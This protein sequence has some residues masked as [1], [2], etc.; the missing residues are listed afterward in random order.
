MANKVLTI[1]PSRGRPDKIV[2]FY[3]CFKSTAT[4]SDLCIAL[5]D[6]DIEYPKFDD[7]I[8]EIN[9]RMFMGGTLNFVAKKYANDYEYLAF[10]GDDHHARTPGW[11]AKLVESIKDLKNGIAYG[12]DLLAGEGLPT[13][14]LLNSNI[15][16]TLGYMSP[17]ELIHL[18]IDNFW[19][20]IGSNLQ[21]LR[22]SEDV[23]IE[24]MHYS[25]K[26]SEEDSRYL[27][28]NDPEV[29]HHDRLVFEKYVNTQLFAD[30]LKLSQ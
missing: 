10:L 12:N 14:V 2:H 11:D 30:L 20:A 17:P 21:T 26:K 18:F 7:V 5:D 29:Y 16:R 4:I 8:Y 23:I 27:E 25:N 1:V 6:D 22:Y 3:N 28:V 9:P 19:K 24:H 15:V 13:A